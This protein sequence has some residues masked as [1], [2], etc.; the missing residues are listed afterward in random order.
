M[1]QTRMLSALIIVILLLSSP[2]ARAAFVPATLSYQGSLYSADNTPFNG[3]KDITFSLYTASTGGT[4]FWTEVQRS[5]HIVNGRF[6]TVLGNTSTLNPASFSTDVWLGIQVSGEAEMTPRQKLTSVAFAFKAD[7]GV[8]VGGIIMWSGAATN[9]PAGWA[10]CDGTTQYGI[11]TPDL[12]GRFVL[13]AGQGAGL[14]ARTVGEAGGEETHKLLTTEMPKHAHS[15]AFVANGYPDSW[16]RRDS[17]NVNGHFIMDP[18]VG[19]PLANF[20]TTQEGSD[21]AHNNMPPYYAL[22]YIMR[23]N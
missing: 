19:P 14:T 12:R 4:A 17:T 1:R 16:G 22:A 2:P 10:L 3:V 8:P 20:S 9:V 18:H 21:V 5:V 11:V 6:A 15:T 7:N 13:G 23:I